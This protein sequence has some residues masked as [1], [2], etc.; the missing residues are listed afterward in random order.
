MNTQR[1]QWHVV[2]IERQGVKLT[3]LDVWIDGKFG[4]SD[5]SGIVAWFTDRQDAQAACQALNVASAAPR[6]EDAEAI[7]RVSALLCEE[8]TGE[9]WTVAGVEHPGV[10]RAYYRELARK[11]V[12]AV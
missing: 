9:P 7:E 6:T 2:P 4:L 1:K 8:E 10:D 3:A 5:G 12:A 11:I